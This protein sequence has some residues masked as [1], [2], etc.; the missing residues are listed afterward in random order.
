[1]TTFGIMLFVSGNMAC[2]LL[3]GAVRPDLAEELLGLGA[4]EVKCGFGWL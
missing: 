1:M 2:L 4:G 3:T